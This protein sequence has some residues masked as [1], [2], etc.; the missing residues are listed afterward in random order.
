ML[1]QEFTLLNNI[2]GYTRKIVFRHNDLSIMPISSDVHEG[3]QCKN[4]NLISLDKDKIKQ[5]TFNNYK[6]IRL[7]Y[8]T[9]AI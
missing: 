1:Q 6:N 8:F 4:I 7:N 9:Q 3:M 2:G 5:S